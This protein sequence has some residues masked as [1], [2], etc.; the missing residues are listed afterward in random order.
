MIAKTFRNQTQ[1]N[2]MKQNKS[3]LFLV[4]LA[5]GFLLCQ[6]ATASGYGYATFQEDFWYDASGR[7]GDPATGGG[8]LWVGPQRSVY[9]T[10]DPAIPYGSLN[11]LTNGLVA[12]YGDRCIIYPTNDYNN[13]P[14]E[15]W[16]NSGQYN[17]GTPG[18]PQAGTNIYISFLY[19]FDDSGTPL[20]SVGQ[21]V[22]QLQKQNS[23]LTSAGNV[24]YM[25]V[26]CREVSGNI[27]LGISKYSGNST[28]YPASTNWAATNLHYGQ[29]FF[30]VAKMAMRGNGHYPPAPGNP[31]ET[32]AL[33]IN[34]NTNSFNG[35]EP[36]PPS[37]FV[38]DGLDDTSP[39]GPGRFYIDSTGQSAEIDEIRIGNYWADVTPQAGQCVNP[40]ILQSPGSVSNANASV[41]C[42]EG[43]GMQMGMKAV[44]TGPTYQWQISNSVAGWVDITN[45]TAR[46]YTTPNLWIGPDNGNKYRTIVYSDCNGKYATTY[47]ATAT[48][49]AATPTPP[50]LI[51]YD[52]FSD[53][54]RDNLPVTTSN[55]VWYTAVSAN[56][57]SSSGFLIGTPLSGSSSLWWGQFVNESTT[58]LPVHLDINRAIKVT[59]PFTPNGFDS[60]TDNGALR[61]GLF[62]YADGGVLLTNDSSLATGSSGNGASVRGYMLSVDFGNNFTADLPLSLWV[63]SSILDISL[64]GTTVDYTS[65]GSGPAGG[66]Y[67]NAPAFRAGTN[68]TLVFQVTRTAT[69]SVTVAVS[70]TGGGT[71]WSYTATET[72]Y[73]YH[74]FDV[75]AIRPYSLETTADSFTFPNF[76][77][78]VMSTPSVTTLPASDLTPGA[79][80]LNGSVN[81]NGAATGAW[82]EWGMN[83]DYGNTTMLTNVGSGTNNLSVSAPISGLVPLTTYHFRMVATNSWGT[84]YGGDAIVLDG[85]TATDWTIIFDE[86]FDGGY[87]GEFGT[88]SYSGGSP[89]GC[90]NYV[91]A[92]GGN[93][94]GCWQVTMTATTSNDYCGGPVQLMTVSGNTDTNPSDYVLSFDA[95]G[96]QAG[97]IQ[98]IIQTWPDT[99]FGGSGPV[100]NAFTNL[101]LTAS[102]TWQ[103]F[104]VNLGSFPGTN[105]PTGATWQF[106]FQLNSWQW[107]GPGN[108]DTL[109][110]DNII[111]VNCLPTAIT[112]QPASQSVLPGTN[113]TFSVSATGS[114]PLS[115]QWRLNGNNIPGATNSTYSISTVQP[116]DGGSYDVLVANP[117]GA[118][119]SLIA[120][121]KVTTAPLPFADNFANRGIT[122]GLSGV[123]SGSNTNATRETGETNHASKYGNHSVWLQWTAPANGV[124]TFNTRGSSFDTLLAVYTG[125]SLSSLSPVAANDD[126]GNGRFTS[127]VQFNAAADTSYIIAVDGLG[128]A[129]GDIVLSWNLV[130]DVPQ[131]PMISTQPADLTVSA[132]SNVTFSVSATCNTSLTYQWYFNDSLAISNATNPSLT[133]SNVG[134]SQVGLYRVK[135][136]SA[137]G[138]NVVSEEGSLEIGPAGAH[139]FDKLEDLLA[140]LLGEEGFAGMGGNGF[141]AALGGGF[142]SVAAGSMD[143]HD[144]SIYGATTDQGEPIPNGGSGATRWYLLTATDNSTF[145][146]DTMGSAISNVLVVYILTNRNLLSVPQ[147]LQLVAR[148]T[149]HNSAPDGTNSMVRFPG[150]TGTNYLIAVA[151][152]VK[153]EQGIINLDWHVGILPTSVGGAGQNQ[154]VCE[155]ATLV[156]QGGDANA[157]P[158]PSY[159][160]L[161]NG[162]NIPG[163]TSTNYSLT[164]IRYNQGGIYSVVVS[165]FMG[166]VTNPIA[167]VCIQSPLRIALEEFS[168]APAFRLTGSATQTIVLQLS[169][170]L[171]SW[172]PLFT[173]HYPSVPINYLDT[174][175][176]ARSSGFYLYKSWP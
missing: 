99:N 90:T 77:V 143:H 1:E 165:N 135:V 23:G 72:N 85:F 76:K 86:N 141:L 112:S 119:A 140:S 114:E 15:K 61:F 156:L 55:S 167:T 70:I 145:M 80:I 107:N 29:T 56:L 166:V 81:P 59:L 171:T 27:N 108:T 142:P 74:R 128:S 136:T 111:L 138:T 43:Q 115:Y 65:M 37:A 120:T 31:Y 11:G 45:A 28:A 64:M 146:L 25:L 32:N 5:S 176:A 161:W 53:M 127:Q 147:P 154:A 169:T 3:S 7:L 160:W 155:G 152:A 133:V 49:T 60:H 87:A 21:R 75:F 91:L 102:N 110:I 158:A 124:A 94:N 130:T 134:L 168:G 8:N 38:D 24:S 95:K 159:Q 144:I 163:Q 153:G 2:T 113:V 92:S 54:Q 39:T 88:G 47:V 58:N 106:L 26:H 10:N 79:A 17:P 30:V 139:S 36:L 173:N 157:V 51:M 73:A 63:R 19:K 122:N 97:N 20:N 123:G 13:A 150:K 175:A 66:G 62:D 129:N 34:P 151:S 40:Y 14:Y 12:S 18:Y 48:V 22:V 172:T 132:G 121:L 4:T 137:A 96:S 109:T 33:W 16:G 82:F 98:L 164:N 126:E 44:A 68:Y 100:I 174:D 42:V 103:T 67:S 69:N 50:G 71:N 104:S 170:N 149:N 89:T 46:N 57:D 131:I 118:V 9:V 41:I 52:N 162:T 105:N 125:T 83:T 116:T 6:N 93:P 101:Q 78:E 117:G 148:D 35:E 84:G